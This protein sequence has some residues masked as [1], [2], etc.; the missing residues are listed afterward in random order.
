ML[1][2][3][4]VSPQMGGLAKAANAW[5]KKHE[6]LVKYFV[7]GGSA[8]ALDIMIFLFIFNI[9]ETTA[10]FA[11]SISVPTA[12]VFSF[13]TNARH[14]FRR[15]DYWALRMALFCLVCTIG[16]AVGYLVIEAVLWAGLSANI[17]KIFSLPLVFVTQ[18]TLNSRVTFREMAIR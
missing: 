9:L 6:H 12:V 17:G 11:H 3:E 10:L 18:Y 13:F 16:Y 8:S 15:S 1:N 5:L 2:L 14:N 4:A 7:I